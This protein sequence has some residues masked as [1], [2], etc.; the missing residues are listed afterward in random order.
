MHVL[1]TLFPLS[2]MH[3]HL[4]FQ[5]T[6]STM[7]NCTLYETIDKRVEVVAPGVRAKPLSL[8][9]LQMR[10]NLSLQY[11]KACNYFVLFPHLY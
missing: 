7:K 3:A 6:S 10:M 2:V 5:R 4:I 9:Y 11:T 8:T 1:P